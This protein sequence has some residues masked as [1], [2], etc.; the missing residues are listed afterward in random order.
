MD[1]VGA[2][3][4]LGVVAA[5]VALLQAE[6]AALT[7]AAIAIAISSF[8]LYHSHRTAQEF[9]THVL[10]PQQRELDAWPETH[11]DVD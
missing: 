5:V 1:Q 10:D 8:S 3:A 11:D 6:Y 2:V 7:L 9:K 4:L